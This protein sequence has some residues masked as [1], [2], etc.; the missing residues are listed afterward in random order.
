VE[1][2][3]ATE[4][5]L[6]CDTDLA[7][8]SEEHVFLAALGGRIS[9]SRAICH[10]CNNS[11]A[12]AATGKLDDHLA[13]GF[14]DI[15][16]GLKIWSGRRHPPPTLPRAGS[17]PN[18]PEFDLAPGFT[19][20]VRP[21]RLPQA[22]K[23]GDII[24][25]TAVNQADLNRQLEILKKRDVTYQLGTPTQQVRKAPEIKRSFAFDN[26]KIW[27]AV[28][29]TA[30]TSFVVL[31]G[32]GQARESVSLE[33]R[34]A[35]RFGSPAIDDFAGWDFTNEWPEIQI[36][37][38]PKTSDALQSGFEHSVIIT[39]V[40]QDCV[41]YVALFGD[42]RFSVRLGPRTGLPPRGLA[43][44]PR[45]AKP[46]RFRVTV[47]APATYNRKHCGSFE[48]EHGVVMKGVTLAFNRALQ[49]WE[50]EAHS[51]YAEQ[52]AKELETK[53]LSVG[54]DE[55][56]RTAAINQFAEKLAAVE[57]GVG[58]SENL[59]LTFD[60]DAKPPTSTQ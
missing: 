48:L 11:F 17:F 22:I 32:N 26:P 5:C 38:H 24:G 34:N 36:D 29:K 44:N 49:Q 7:P 47:K 60:E 52:L 21:G 25:I 20:V 15:R 28:A 37:P 56:A 30:V 9:T 18:G 45:S 2:E 13:D 43:V 40:G 42:W 6:F 27:R 16:N 58:W 35:V 12:S 33:L 39:D 57:L 31:H 23:V 50:A 51:E 8:G 59:N 41:A 53:V 3:T 14:K 55:S 46:A 1:T 10:D 4:K 19:P 54:E